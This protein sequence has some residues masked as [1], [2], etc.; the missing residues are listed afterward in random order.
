MK[1]SF[2][3]SNSGGFSLQ[4]ETCF[5]HIYGCSY[6]GAE[7]ACNRAWAIQGAKRDQRGQIMEKKLFKK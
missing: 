2:I 6:K 5:N 4:H 7:Y 3:Y 1:P